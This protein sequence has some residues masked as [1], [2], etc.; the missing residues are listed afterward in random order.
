[1]PAVA[2]RS[3]HPADRAVRAG[4]D[5]PEAV[6]VRGAFAAYAAGDDEAARAALQVIGLSSP[7]LDWKLLLRGRIAHAAGDD[8]RAGEN[9]KRL[10]PRRLPAKL[11]GLFNPT[12]PTAAR[13]ARKLPGGE[14]PERLA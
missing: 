7:V 1:M 13:Q 9:W 2:S 6:A 8:A 3:V 10:D 14:L 4:D 11:A 12:T 5:S